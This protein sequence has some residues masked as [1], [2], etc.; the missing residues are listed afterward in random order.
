MFLA[1]PIT[2]ISTEQPRPASRALSPPKKWGKEE[3][4]E[5]L[6]DLGSILALQLAQTDLHEEA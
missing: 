2:C 3:D 4:S 6:G 1:L 5:H